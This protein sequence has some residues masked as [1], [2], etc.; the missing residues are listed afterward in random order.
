MSRRLKL[1][2]ELNVLQSIEISGPPWSDG[3]R[4]MAFLTLTKN[5]Y[6]KNPGNIQEIRMFSFTAD[7]S[8]L[9]VERENNMARQDH[10]TV[11]N[12]K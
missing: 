3:H 4:S 6:L 8:L 10:E 2:Y 1:R 12:G 9:H 11:N 7:T 5:G